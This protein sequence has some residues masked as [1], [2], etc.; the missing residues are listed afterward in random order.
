MPEY[1]GRR[2]DRLLAWPGCANST[3][4]RRRLGEGWGV[5]ARC[6]KRS[7]LPDVLEALLRVPA[8]TPKTL[9]VRLKV[10]PQTGTALLREL[11]ARGLCGR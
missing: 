5:I 10:A 8:L 4:S 3:G 9:A 1:P 7:R 11:Q 6:D 2:I